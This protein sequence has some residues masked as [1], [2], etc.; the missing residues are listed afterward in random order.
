MAK[1]KSP[2]FNSQF[3][4]D[5]RN[6]NAARRLDEEIEKAKQ[7]LDEAVKGTVTSSPIVPDD[8]LEK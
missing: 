3:W 5:R 8:C 2:K 7:K 4:E 6:A 1:I